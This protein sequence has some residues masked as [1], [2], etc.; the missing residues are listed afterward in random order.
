MMTSRAQEAI[1]FA[2]A[3]ACVLALV[4][5]IR[6]LCVRWRIFDQPGDL[7]IHGE[8]IPRLG[9]VGIAFALAAGVASAL[10]GAPVR[11]LYFAA[12]LGL[13]WLAGFVDDLRELGPASRLLAQIGAALLLYA[14]G[15]RVAF[16]SS[17]AWAIV[18]QC[19]FVLLFVNAFNFLDGA[20]GL[21][22][23]ITAA[24]ALGYAAMPGLALSGLGYAL[25]WSLLGACVGFLFFNFP[26]ARIFMGDSGST[27]L[28]FSVAF[29]GLDFVGAR[30]GGVA[31]SSW[32]FPFLIAAV[33]LLDALVVATRRVMQGKSPFQGDREHF[34]DFLLAAGWTA[35][36]VAICCYFLTCFLGLLGWFAVEG[37]VRP[38]VILGLGIFAFFV[39]GALCLG[40]RRGAMKR[41]R[42]RVQ[43]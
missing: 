24:I 15:W 35:R 21:A 41:S 11:E 8:P 22:A 37:A 17:S 16:S 32:L 3:L 28:G 7:K 30:G 38:A 9:G 26:P 23:G 6:R 19:V 18:A 14:G 10:H 43:I 13:V 5:L 40:A 29:L 12:A 42:Y 20:D 25:A 36:R 34:Y 27:V 4:P 33:P 1:A 39:L 2:V 31:A